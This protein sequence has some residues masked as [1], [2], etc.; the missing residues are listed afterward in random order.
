MVMAILK[1]RLQQPTLV[2]MPLLPPAKLPK[3]ALVIGVMAVLVGLIV[4]ML[5]FLQG[6]PFAIISL[7][8]VTTGMLVIAVSQQKRKRGTRSR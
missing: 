4:M 6:R 8:P 2:A 5:D 1:T 3:I 7:V